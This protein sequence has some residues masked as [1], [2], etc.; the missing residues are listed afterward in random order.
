MQNL[1]GRMRQVSGYQPAFSHPSRS[2]GGTNRPARISRAER[3]RMDFVAI[4]VP[5]GTSGAVNINGTAS[6]MPCPDPLGAL[7]PARIDVGGGQNS[8]HHAPLP[9]PS[10]GIYIPL[11]LLYA[12]L[13]LVLV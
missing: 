6:V 7:W 10:R 13:T 4:T 8:L 1:E 12:G 2:V 3:R 11:C 5:F 9:L